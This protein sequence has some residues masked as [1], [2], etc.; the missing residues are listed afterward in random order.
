MA[1]LTK[2]LSR[3]RWREVRDLKAFTQWPDSTIWR[4]SV[5]PGAAP[6]V[7]AVL[8]QGGLEP[9]YLLDWGG[10]LMWL[11]LPPSEDGHAPTMRASLPRSGGHATLFRAPAAVRQKVAVFEPQP[12]ALAALSQRLKAA[13]DPDDIL[14]PGRMVLR[15]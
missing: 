2:E 10:G 7:L 1:R 3:Q 6:G 14:N 9:H 12:E 13:F 4:L 5:A 8:Q 11:A 15:G